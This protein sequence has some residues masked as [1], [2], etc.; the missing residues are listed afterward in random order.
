MTPTIVTFLQSNSRLA[1]AMGSRF[2]TLEHETKEGY[3]MAQRHRWSGR[4][5]SDGFQSGWRCVSEGYCWSG[6]TGGLKWYYNLSGSLGRLVFRT[7]GLGDERIV[8]ICLQKSI[9]RISSE[10]AEE[11]GIKT[12][13]FSTGMDSNLFTLWTSVNNIFRLE[14][15]S[16][17]ILFW[18]L[19]APQWSFEVNLL[20]VLV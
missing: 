11:T 1:P 13:P 12:S 5:Q 14:S 9:V 7:R 2:R 6:K 19:S 3:W 15:Y 8:G 18:L 20:L 16:K 17:F 10:C 4:R